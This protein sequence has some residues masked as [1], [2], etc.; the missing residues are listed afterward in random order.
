MVLKIGCEYCF[1]GQITEGSSGG[2]FYTNN[3]IH[4]YETYITLSLFTHEGG[5]ERDVREGER[6]KSDISS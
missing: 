6:V 2:R 5:S 3:R 1:K 4:I